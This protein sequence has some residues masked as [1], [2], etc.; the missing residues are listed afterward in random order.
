MGNVQ[1]ARSK[2]DIM[3]ESTSDSMNEKVSILEIKPYLPQE[4]WQIVFDVMSIRDKLFS[5]KHVIEFEEFYS[6][7]LKNYE[8]YAANFRDQEVERCALLGLKKQSD[9]SLNF[10]NIPNI[11]LSIYLSN[12]SVTWLDIDKSSHGY[13]TFET[14][15]EKIGT[16]EHSTYLKVNNVCWLHFVVSKIL[17]PTGQYNIF[18][19]IRGPCRVAN[20]YKITVKHSSPCQDDVGYI[21]L[22]QLKKLDST[23]EWV[24]VYKDQNCKE[25]LKVCYNYE[26][27]DALCVELFNQYGSWTRG[28][29]FHVIRFA[30]AE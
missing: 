1:G 9:D 15:D 2:R 28:V 12:N 18:Y 11:A 26:K 24:P 22:K 19:K 21:D 17:L 27:N 29:S 4:I 20:D 16:S 5:S 3:Y 23:W 30:L 6:Q 7:L 25:L 10:E 13:L 8:M 14:D